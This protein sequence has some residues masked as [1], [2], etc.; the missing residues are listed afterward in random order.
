[1][2]SLFCVAKPNA[3]NYLLK[4]NLLIS[5]VGALLAS[6]AAASMRNERII[7]LCYWHRP[8]L[9]TR[10]DIRI[11]VLLCSGVYAGI[12]ITSAI[13][14]YLSEAHYARKLRHSSIIIKMMRSSLK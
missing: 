10:L 5:N 2:N 3:E 4:Q 7:G 11:E 14:I 9:V 13:T 8:S 6:T 1:M 12:T